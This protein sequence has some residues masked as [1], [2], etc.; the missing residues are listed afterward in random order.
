VYRLPPPSLA[1]AMAQQPVGLLLGDEAV[2][3]CLLNGGFINSIHGCLHLGKIYAQ[4]QGQCRRGLARCQSCFQLVHA[5]AQG[6][7]DGGVHDGFVYQVQVEIA[8]DR[9]LIAICGASRVGWPLGK[10]SAG[11]GE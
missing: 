6:V 1:A 3:N 2:G 9:C 7:G 5:D 11:H 8:I 4:F 10:G